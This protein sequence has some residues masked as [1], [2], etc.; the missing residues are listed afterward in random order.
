MTSS[1]ILYLGQTTPLTLVLWEQLSMF[2]RFPVGP[3]GATVENWEAAIQGDARPR[4]SSRAEAAA[5]FSLGLP[6]PRCAY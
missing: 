2:P 5:G 1:W 4:R 3:V 6:L